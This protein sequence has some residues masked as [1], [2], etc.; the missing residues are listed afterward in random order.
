MKILTTFVL[1]I[2]TFATV[3]AEVRLPAII[4]NHMVLQQKSRVKLWG[5][6]EPGEKIKINSTW[7]TTS[8]YTTGSTEAKWLTEIQT[9]AA[10]G[11]YTITI[12]GNNKIELED[13]MIGEVWICSG[14]SNMEMNYN[15]GL[16]EYTN[17]M[18]NATNKSIRFFHIP[19]LT[20]GFPQDDTKAKWVVCNP[21]DVKQFSAVGYF[22][23][24][25]LY[26]NLQTA[27]GLIE[28]SWGGTPA[29]VWT[30]KEVIENDSILKRAAN[31]ITPGSGWPVKAGAT[32]N[33][34]IHPVTNYNIAGVIWYQGESNTGT[35]D[36][37]QQLFTAMIG[38]WRRAW[39]SEM[40]FYYV[41]IAPF[42][43]GTPYIGAALREAQTKTL[44]TPKTRMVVISDLV[45]DVNDIHPKIKKEVGVRLANLA[46]SD[47]YGKLKPAY[48]SPMYKNLE[49]KGNK[50]RIYFDNVENGLMIKGRD[51]SDFYIAEADKKFVKAQVKIEGNTVVVSGK[52]IKN[53]VAVRFGFSNT[54]M[55]NLFSKEGLPVNLFRTDNWDLTSN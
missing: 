8:Y 47:A 15:W 41:Q 49:V 22:F 2:S 30:P 44:A 31:K 27:V 46:L 10:G 54:A 11:P 9:P 28:A 3:K 6:C 14:Q 38:A 45:N 26:D 42:A 50:V 19:R 4:G 39:Q 53:P 25:T 5:W 29:E 23:G 55:P 20:S 13:V 37:Y 7:D 17:D 36:T 51:A 32:Y 33:A 34:M 1:L 12:N 16:K 43:Y 18:E 48:K 52:E 24:R 21:N 40:P 35:F